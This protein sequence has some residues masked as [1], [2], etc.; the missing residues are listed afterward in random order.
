MEISLPNNRI[1]SVL[2]GHLKKDIK[3]PLQKITVLQ[4]LS[5]LQG[6]TPWITKNIYHIELY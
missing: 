3:K 4:S 6:Q 2:L 5:E 1:T